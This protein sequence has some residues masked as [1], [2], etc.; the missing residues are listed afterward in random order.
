MPAAPSSVPTARSVAASVL[1]RVLKDAA[2]A[3]AALDAEVSR[4]VQLEPR[5]RGLA[6]ELVYGSLR[7]LPWLDARILRHA[8]RGLD[9]VDPRTRAE[10]TLSAYQ[11]F[12]L[13]RVPAF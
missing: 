2:F 9:G 6:T 13:A 11:L 7:V 8:P 4:S 5:D 10:M 12:F 3:S 1:V